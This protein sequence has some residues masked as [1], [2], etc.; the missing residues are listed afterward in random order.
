M[1]SRRQGLAPSKSG[2][3]PA[4]CAIEA[5]SVVC[6]SGAFVHRGLGIRAERA[7]KDSF[8][9]DNSRDYLAPRRGSFFDTF[10]NCG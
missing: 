6:A 5:G 9:R 1:V 10:H 7:R 2:R 4:D 8:A 3:F